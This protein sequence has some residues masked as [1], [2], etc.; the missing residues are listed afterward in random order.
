MSQ[1]F[2]TRVG[3]NWLLLSHVEGSTWNLQ[4][5][6]DTPLEAEVL[7]EDELQAK[8]T[9]LHAAVERLRSEQPSLKVPTDAVWSA[10]FET[11]WSKRTA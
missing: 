9:S 11:R 4:V 2:S 10:V 5:L 6:G 7:A 1:K 3:K 8:D